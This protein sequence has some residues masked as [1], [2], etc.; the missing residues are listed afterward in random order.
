MF[1]TITVIAI[2]FA[3]TFP[4]GLSRFEQ[5]GTTPR[6][7]VGLYVLLFFGCYLAVEMTDWV[8]KKF[9]NNKVI[10]EKFNF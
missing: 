6:V 9:L 7:M 10:S 3:T 1:T 4:I 5:F 8:Q 2:L